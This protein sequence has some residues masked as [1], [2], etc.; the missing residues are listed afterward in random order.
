MLSRHSIASR[1]NNSFAFA[2]T[3]LLTLL[4]A[5]SV[6]TFV[7]SKET[8]PAHLEIT[9]LQVVKGRSARDGQSDY[10]FAK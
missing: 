4:A 8:Q 5:V 7:I 2:T 6:T 3:V 10:A 9:Q 1:L